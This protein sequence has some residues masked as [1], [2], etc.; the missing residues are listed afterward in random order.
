MVTEGL[1]QKA[2]DKFSNGLFEKQTE[3][4]IHS[5]EIKGNHYEERSY[6]F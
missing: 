4:V 3:L 5:K 6:G 2:R 1:E